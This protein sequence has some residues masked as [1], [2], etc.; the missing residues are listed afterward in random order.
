MRLDDSLMCPLPRKGNIAVTEH[1]RDNS[2]ADVLGPQNGL[3]AE[4]TELANRLIETLRTT[5]DSCDVLTATAH[6]VYV[7]S[8]DGQILFT[9]AS[10]DTVFG[11]GVSPVGRYASAFLDDVIG[12]VAAESDKLLLNGCSTIQFDHP[13]RDSQG[14]ELRLRTV[15]KSLLGMGHPKAA[16]LGLTQVLHVSA[17]EHALKV[18]GLARHWQ[19]FQRLDERDR[20]IAVLLSEGAKSRPIAEQ[21]DVTEKTVDNRRSHILRHLGLKNT[22]DLARLLCRL[23]DNGFCD[24]GL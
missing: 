11:H 10:Y 6:C 4:A 22:M 21:F 14:R 13:G 15:K 9:N 7:K 20:R 18:F 2:I 17:D 5:S 24:F 16:I 8:V 1:G 19:V 23:Q 3:D 12:T